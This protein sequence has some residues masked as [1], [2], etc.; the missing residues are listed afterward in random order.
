MSDSYTPADAPDLWQAVRPEA[1]TMSSAQLLKAGKRV[2]TDVRNTAAQ[3]YVAAVMHMLMCGVLLIFSETRGQ[4]I[5]VVLWFVGWGFLILQIRGYRRG[6]SAAVAK[7]SDQ[8]CVDFY[9]ALLE[10]QRSFFHGAPVWQRFI[11]MST[12]P[13]VFSAASAQLETGGAALF[14]YGVA[15]AF[16]A[17]IALSFRFAA[18]QAAG[19]QKQIDALQQFERSDR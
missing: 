3:S 1:P 2:D 6:V 18:R 15:A 16:V 10:R 8:P 12:G 9:R 17:L 19:F 11:A 13:F 14:A 7:M 5:G 4:Q